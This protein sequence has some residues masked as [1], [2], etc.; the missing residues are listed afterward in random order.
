MCRQRYPDTTVEYRVADLFS[1]PEEWIHG[2]DLVYECN[3]IQILKGPS[4]SAAITAISD[5]VAP[6]GVVLV[7]CRSRNAGEGLN[8]FP[9]ALDKKEIDGFQ[10]TGLL[11]THFVAYDDDQNPPVPHYFAIYKRSTEKLSWMPH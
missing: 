9:V 6:R 5:I 1:L 8:E 10:R 7:S 11:E 4:R 3:T 2:F